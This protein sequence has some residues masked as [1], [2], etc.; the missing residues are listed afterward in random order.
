[1]PLRASLH[2]GSPNYPSCSAL[3]WYSCWS[4]LSPWGESWKRT[5]VARAAVLTRCRHATQPTCRRNMSNVSNAWRNVLELCNEPMNISWA[6]ITTFT[7]PPNGRQNCIPF[8]VPTHFQQSLTWSSQLQNIANISRCHV[9]YRLQV[10]Q[11]PR[12]T[13]KITSQI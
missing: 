6:I 1:M 4:A 9:V 2:P 5:R 7:T 8:W 13:D 3:A 10:K 12:N 11:S